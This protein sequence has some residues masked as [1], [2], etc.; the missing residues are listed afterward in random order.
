MAAR[1][2]SLVRPLLALTLLAMG[3]GE[4]GPMPTLERPAT[5]RASVPVDHHVHLI[6][7]GLLADWKSVGVSFS[8]P[9]AAYQSA[10]AL[11]GPPPGGDGPVERVVLVPMAHLYGNSELRGALDISVEEEQR[12]V[13]AEN[14][15]VAG[16]AARYPGR[17]LAL[18]SVSVLRPYARDEL[19]RCLELPAAGGVKL[20]LASSE[21]DLREPSH[22]AA[23]E[24]LTALA[25]ERDA[26]LLLHLDP[27]RRG[28]E[29]SDIGRFAQTVLEPHPRLT[30]V[31]AHLGGSGGYGPWTQSVF[32]TLLSWLEQRRTAGEAREGIYFD[33]S[34]AVL[35][36][37]SEGVPAT[38]ADEAA[39]LADDLR[40]IGF[41]RI[42]LG[43][44]YPVFEPLRVVAV[45]EER[46]GLTSPE[47]DEIL[48][49]HVPQL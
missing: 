49:R 30:V 17:A 33:L 3:C 34:A 22:L 18:C 48:A 20:H 31:V 46:V 23:I 1:L 8:R 10:A 35:E 43:S 39:A 37:P 21:V 4:S 25:E 47:V 11:L 14:D 44:D 19:E 9:D 38:T 7:P 41:E 36:E 24:Q 32:R 13:A 16:E 27:Q 26:L 42:V 45:L 2:P 29:A 28:L 12:R 15:H 40:R 6:G 5:V